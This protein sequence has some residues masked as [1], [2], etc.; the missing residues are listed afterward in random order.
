METTHIRKAPRP[1]RRWKRDNTRR[2][3]NHTK[4]W[5]SEGSSSCLDGS[6]HR[7]IPART[8]VLTREGR[9]WP[10][11]LRYVPQLHKSRTCSPRETRDS[12]KPL[13]RLRSNL[14]HN[15]PRNEQHVISTAEV[16]QLSKQ[17][18]LRLIQEDA[19]NESVFL[20][21]DRQ[22]GQRRNN[23][24][25]PDSV[26]L[27]RS[28]RRRGEETTCFPCSNLAEIVTVPITSFRDETV[29]NENSS[30][31]VWNVGDQDR[32]CPLRRDQRT[33]D[34]INVG[35]SNEN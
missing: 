16:E 11:P 14:T 1:V 24:D 35:D 2:H 34:P 15:S 3:Y 4:G 8:V 25:S 27:T 31:I 23:G 29:E 13:T 33:Y 26:H 18:E 10:T 22:V 21:N 6:S 5:R 28:W 17:R 32:I 19:E 9:G 7:W 12:Q 20:D 30:F